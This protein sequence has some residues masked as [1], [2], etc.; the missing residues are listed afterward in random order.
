MSSTNR[1][2][3]MSGTASGTDATDNVHILNPSAGTVRAV[4]FYL[5]PH[6]S[7][8]THASNYITITV[9]KGSSVLATFTTNSSGGA[10]LTAG[11]PVAL[12]IT[13]TGADLEIAAA[14]VYTV[15]VAKSGTGPSYKFSAVAVVEAVH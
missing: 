11:T 10:A 1:L 6:V 7:V 5:V 8:A 14:G 15:E 4:S 9:K 12:T 13:G 2:Y 3:P